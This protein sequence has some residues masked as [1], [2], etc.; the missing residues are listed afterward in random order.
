M[1]FDIHFAIS[2]F[3]QCFVAAKTTLLITVVSLLIGLP[4]AFAR[5][6]AASPCHSAPS[7]GQAHRA[8]AGVSSPPSCP[9]DAPRRP[10][11]Q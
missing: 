3:W 4:L 8:Q 11:L 10:R 6:R 2:L 5:W 7:I 1:S 9:E